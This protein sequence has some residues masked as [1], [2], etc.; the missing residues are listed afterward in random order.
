MTAMLDWIDVNTSDAGL[1]AAFAILYIAINW[2]RI[3]DRL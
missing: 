3:H 1:I 2:R